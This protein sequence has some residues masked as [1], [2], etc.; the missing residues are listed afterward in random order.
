[1]TIVSAA[2][3][4]LLTCGLLALAANARAQEHTLCGV[5]GTY[6]LS[7]TRLSAPGPAQVGG[8]L[9]FTPPEPCAPGIAGAV[10]IDLVLVSPDGRRE[11]YRA[12]EPVVAQGSLIAIGH[13]LVAASSGVAGGVVTSLAVN[14]AGAVVFA[15]ILTRQSIDAIAGPAGPMGPAGPVG[16]SGPGGPP[17]P[18]GMTGAAGPA[19]PPGQAGP[20]GPAGPVGST[21]STGPV[22]PMGPA[23]P[24]GS[25]GSMGPVGPIGPVGPTGSVGPAGPAGPQGAQGIPGLAGPTGPPGPVGPAGPSG[26][27]IGLSAYGGARLDAEQKNVTLASGADLIF[28]RSEPAS[29]VA[30]KTDSAGVVVERRGIYRV[31]WTVIYSRDDAAILALAIDDEVEPSTRVPLLPDAGQAHGMALLE[32][33]DGQRITLRNDG[34]SAITLLGSPFVGARLFVERID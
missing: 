12:T 7:G 11:V 19:G 4:L 22:G 13:R 8:T 31:T 29:G 30:H 24:V 17:G 9:V 16:P 3:A 15:G 1:M 28:A 34:P 20:A 18:T 6:L 14:G 21:G 23:G 25:T 2:R 26:P 5:R 33:T 32:L 27:S 10:A